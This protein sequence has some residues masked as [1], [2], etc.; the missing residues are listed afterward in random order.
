MALCTLVYDMYTGRRYRSSERARPKLRARRRD[1]WIL[2]LLFLPT[3][4][5]S[6]LQ[7]RDGRSWT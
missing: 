6:I 4:S 2:P 3:S 7:L 5:S 1:K